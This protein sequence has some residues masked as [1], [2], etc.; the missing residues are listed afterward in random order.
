M[1]PA[2]LLID[3][4]QGFDEPYWGIRNNPNFED[5]ITTLLSHWRQCGAH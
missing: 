2:L 3:I 1:K 4:Q 5:N